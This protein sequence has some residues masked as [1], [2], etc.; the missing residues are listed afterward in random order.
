MFVDPEMA[1]TM[2]KEYYDE[3]KPEV[4]P[5]NDPNSQNPDDK[6]GGGTGDQGNS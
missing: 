3:N 1:Y 5:P 2:S 6:S 4:I